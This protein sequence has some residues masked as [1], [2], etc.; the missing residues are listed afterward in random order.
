VDQRGELAIIEQKTGKR[1]RPAGRRRFLGACVEWTP[2][3]DLLG[4]CELASPQPDPENRVYS[5]VGVFAMREGKY[6]ELLAPIWGESPSLR[7]VRMDAGG[8]AT[9]ERALKDFSLGR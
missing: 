5:F 6:R 9:L 4:L 3:S 7:W 8:I 1:I 2:D